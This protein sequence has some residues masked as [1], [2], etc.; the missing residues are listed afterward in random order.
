MRP[1]QKLVDDAFEDADEKGDT[2]TAAVEVSIAV[3]VLFF[4]DVHFCLFSNILQRAATVLL[5]DEPVLAALLQNIECVLEPLTFLM[6][7]FYNY[8]SVICLS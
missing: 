4:T 6:I 8:Y 1:L 5:R 2:S 3:S 7:V